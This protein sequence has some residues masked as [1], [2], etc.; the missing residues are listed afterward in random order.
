MVLSGGW[1]RW[2]YT[3]WVLK[4]LEELWLD[5][6]IKAIF[7]VSAWAII[8]SLWANGMKAEEIYK[9]WTSL[10][11]SK[12][13]GKDIFTKTWWVLSNKKIKKIIDENLPKKFSSLKKKMYI[14][15]VDTNTAKYMLFDKGNLQDIVLGS[16]SIPGVFPPVEYK[17][18]L[19]VDGGVLDNFPVDKA[20]KKY[21][22]AKII[23]VALNKF[24]KNQKIKTVIDNIMVTFE[25]LLRAKLL[26]DTKKVDYLFYKK[27][28]IPILSLDK[29]K[30]KKVYDMW[31]KDCMRK[32]K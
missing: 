29:K 6:N 26:E 20:K 12:F 30:M 24:E 10:S 9:L 25:I 18:Y 27:I 22:K 4:W 31:Y 1:F 15:V 16:M 5:K 7:G 32:F 11:F 17:D 2:F 8:W 19:F 3:I 21:S 28:P 14:G 23:W 13:Y